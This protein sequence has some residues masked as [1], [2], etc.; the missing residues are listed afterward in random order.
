MNVQNSL[1]PVCIVILNWNNAPDTLDC[2]ESVS[3]LDYPDYSIVVVDNGSTDGSADKIRARYP[4]LDI[5]ELETNL[6][7]AAGNN[8]GIHY[9]LATGTEY[10]LVLNNDTLVASTMLTELVQVAESQ[11]EVGMIG[12]TMY[13]VDP[14]DALFAAGSFISW[15]RGETHNRGMFQPTAGYT[16]LKR[17]E[18]VDYIAG[19][20]VL[21][22]RQLIEATGVLDP[23]YYLNFEDVEWG[24][25][26]QRHGFEVIYVP[27]AIMWHKVSATLGQASPANTYYMTRNSLL[28]FW[29][30]APV[31]VRWLSIS[32]IVFRT[33]R[34]MGAWTFKASYRSDSFER[35]RKANLFAL[36]DF[37]LGRFGKM[38]PDVASVCYIDK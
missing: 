25:Q 30:N 18:P 38:G 6:G 29:R 19:C 24:V 21:V 8:V 34:S 4:T 33:L 36:R 16:G 14:T 15:A 20:C 26:A 22:R 3:K 35:L 10:I 13:C 17:P 37:L 7:Y 31:L 27:Q 9:A 23:V 2:L 11:P 32:R 5:L 12:P 28:F 1:P